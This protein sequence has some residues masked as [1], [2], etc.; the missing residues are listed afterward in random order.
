MNTSIKSWIYWNICENIWTFWLKL[1]YARKDL[2]RLKKLWKNEFYELSSLSSNSNS[3]HISSSS[4]NPKLKIDSNSTQVKKLWKPEFYELSSLRSNSNSK[5]I[6]SSSLNPKLKI[7][8]NST[9][10]EMYCIG[11]ISNQQVHFRALLERSGRHKRS[12]T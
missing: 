11:L 10:H 5:N 6:L 7:D 9:R 3:K 1:K 12:A 2:T 4:L 8:S